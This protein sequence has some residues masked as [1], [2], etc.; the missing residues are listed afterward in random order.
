LAGLLLSASLALFVKFRAKTVCFSRREQMS[1]F[2]AK[3]SENEAAKEAKPAPS[4]GRLPFGVLPEFQRDPLGLYVRTMQHYPEIVRMRFAHRWSYTIYHPDFVKHILVDNNRNYKRNEFGNKLLKIV[5]GENLVTSD[6]DFWRKQRRLMQ[7]AFHRKRIESFGRIMTGAAEAMLARW[8]KLPAGTTLMVDEEMMRVTLQVVGEALFSVDLTAEAH[9][10]GRVITESSEYFAYRLANIFA[11][12]L[13]VPT[14]RN[15]R[16]K[17]AVASAAPIVPEMIAAR[18]HHI[19]EHGPAEQAGRAYDMLDLLLEARYEETGEGMEDG[20]LNREVQTMI[21]AGHETTSNSLTW[22]LYLLSKHPEVEVRLHAEV[23]QLL[24]G[25]VP[26][27]EDLPRLP[28]TQQVMEEAM[29]LYPAAWAMSRQSIGEDQLGP[30]PLPANASV[31]LPIYAVH[32]HPDFW[33]EAE[34]FDPDRFSEEKKE[35]QHRFAYF[36]FGGGPRQCIGN[37]FALMEARLILA[38]IAQRYSL[39]TAPGYTAIPE[40]LVTLRVRNGLP[41]TLEPRR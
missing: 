39:R 36:P 18:R 28:Y 27:I 8:G 12:P 1:L 15:R 23:D 26:T 4:I 34:R 7:P 2:T 31:V 11:P 29:R 25:R 17:N 21:T 32:R 38:M 19:A 22:A 5:S 6:G 30:Y 3:S 33:E 35:K 13:W 40:P 9:E 37:T 14:A 10:L 16:F 20:Q 41:M 24:K